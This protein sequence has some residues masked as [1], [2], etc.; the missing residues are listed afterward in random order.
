MYLKTVNT[1]VY[2]RKVKIQKILQ[3]KLKKAE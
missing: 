1:T 3:E 2:D